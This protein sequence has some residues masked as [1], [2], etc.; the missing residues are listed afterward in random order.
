MRLCNL[1]F[2]TQS[3]YFQVHIF[4]FYFQSLPLNYRIHSFPVPQRLPEEALTRCEYF[5]TGIAYNPLQGLTYIP[6]SVGQA[7]ITPDQL[8]VGK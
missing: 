6:F 3:P 1:K 7:K 8:A 2:Y 4:D 5:N